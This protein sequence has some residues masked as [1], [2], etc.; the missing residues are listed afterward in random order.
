MTRG[1]NSDATST[2]VGSSPSAASRTNGNQR[3]TAADLIELNTGVSLEL[4][5]VRGKPHT[6]SDYGIAV[7]PNEPT[8]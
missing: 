6:S 2:P 4:I 8:P 5:P 7:R 1:L 3:L